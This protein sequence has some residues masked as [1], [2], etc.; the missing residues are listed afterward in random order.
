MR[1]S[2]LRR[3]AALVVLLPAFALATS[4][5]ERPLAERARSADRVVLAQVLESKTVVTEMV[6]PRVEGG[7]PTPRMVTV[8][9]LA[10][11]EDYRGSGPSQIEVVQL[12]GRFGLWEAHVPGDATFEA[13]ETAI[14]LLRCRDAASPG[15][16]TLVNLGEG[17]LQVVGPD[18]IERSITLG[19]STRRPLRAV[20]DLLRALPQVTR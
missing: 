4:I 5:V 17:K 6:P 16:C 3:C 13:G 2:R 12:G 11:G 20:A 9:R 14:L 18:V 8:T 10:V 7:R 15:R 19:Q 1:P